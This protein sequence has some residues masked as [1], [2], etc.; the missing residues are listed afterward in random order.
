MRE[1]PKQKVRKTKNT[2]LSWSTRINSEAWFHRIFTIAFDRLIRL[3][4][5]RVNDCPAGL[6]PPAGVKNRRKTSLKNEETRLLN[7]SD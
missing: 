7:L 6:E 3:G 4:H 5:L 1:K 2:T